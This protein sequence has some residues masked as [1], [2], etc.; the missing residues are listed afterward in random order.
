M[1]QTESDV[2][3]KVGDELIPAHKQILV[4]K[5]KYFDGLFKSGMAESK[6]KIIEINDCKAGTFKGFFI[7][8]FL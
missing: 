6:Q 5:S 2:T 1:S 4:R 8:I 3:F 7:E